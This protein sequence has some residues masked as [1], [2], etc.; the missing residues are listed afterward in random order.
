VLVATA[1]ATTASGCGSSAKSGSGS[2]DPKVASAYVVAQ[3]R[4]LCLVQ[5]KAYPTLAALRTAYQR[6]ERSA[7]FTADGLARAQAAAAQDPALR[8][9]ISNRVAATCGRHG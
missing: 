9:R 2:L 6:A 5:S 8:T 4:A 1:L 7:S 3:A